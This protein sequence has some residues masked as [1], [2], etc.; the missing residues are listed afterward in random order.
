MHKLRIPLAIVFALFASAANLPASEAP[1]ET[2]Q[3]R[4]QR[5]AWWRDARFGMFIHWGLYAVPAGTWQGKQIGGIGEWIMHNA[6][7]PVADYENLTAQF[8]PVKF[9][10]DQWV[11]IAK[12]AGMKYMVIT[13]K[14]HDGFAMF[15]SKA[16]PY[17]IYDATSFHRDPLAE[18][19]AACKRQGM[20]LGFYYSQCQDWHHPGAEAIGGH[21]DKAQ[22]GSFDRYLDTVAIPQVHEI[23]TN[24]PLSVLWW[25]TP[26]GAMTSER[27]AKLAALLRLRPG[28]ITNDR[29]GGGFAGDTNTPEQFIPATGYPGRDWETCMTMNDTW[30]Y[31]SYDHNWKSPETLIRNLADIASKGGNYLLNVGPTA[32][33]EI[34][35][36]SVERL[37]AVGRWMDLNG[38]A[39]YG[40]TASPFKKLP[41]GRCTQKPGRLYLHV[42]AWPA[43]ELV[44]PGLK[45]RVTGAYLLADK[46]KTVLP[47]SARENGL[48]V[49][50]STEAP[51][52]IDSV[53][54]LEIEGKPDVEPEILSQNKA[55]V[56]ELP[57][58]EAMLH[59]DSLR[60]Q[61]DSAGENIGF[62]TNPK[63]WASWE[64]KIDRP[65]RFDVELT[66][67][68]EPGSADSEYEV[69]LAEEEKAAKG[70]RPRKRIVVTQPEEK[71]LGK[72]ENT[73]SWG[74]FVVVKLGTITIA[75]GCH[76]LSVKPTKMPHGAVMNLRSIVLKPAGT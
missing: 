73:G 20:R 75:R 24:Y 74:Q 10:A 28:L 49:K 12:R 13:S 37:A 6:K 32:E 36:A 43:G 54:V 76:V 14:H 58:G 61:G 50:L 18:L 62:W 68:C 52:R 44:V 59:G 69:T 39:I 4:D 34:P 66:F 8:N 67:A 71:L 48:S 46:E 41:W 47:V 35:P 16:S 65:G 51:D 55:G 57:A 22:D 9:N 64:F 17:N 60:C 29:L 7:I 45:N 26:T 56:V 72:V 31:K 25:D 15:H 27:A 2:K 19:A 38:A 5:M 42:F 33:G 40:T 63:D 23:L 53:V 3:E 30:G 21:W 11:S 70:L 1:Q